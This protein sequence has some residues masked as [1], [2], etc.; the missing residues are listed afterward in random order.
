[1]NNDNDPAPQDAAIPGM[2]SDEELEYEIVRTGG[3]EYWP[4]RENPAGSEPIKF[5]NLPPEVYE[6][7]MQGRVA[8]GP[9][10][11]ANAYQVELW[12]HHNDRIEAE[13]EYDRAW[14][15]YNA[16]GSYDPVTG[17]PIYSA[18]AQRRNALLHDL[19]A[20]RDR[21]ERLA[22]KYG[23]PNLER[24]LKVAV[25][26]R[27]ELYRRRYIEAEAQ[28]RASAASVEAEIAER[29]RGIRNAAGTAR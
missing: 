9:G 19:V 21:Q 2:P 1:M 8:Q 23:H 25:A 4:M 6:R 16:V 27:K 20:I 7:V 28:R 12:K 14:N 17:D 5:A 24:A 22:G 15:E 18:S 29:V 13:R 11:Y 10:Q 26:Q 3:P